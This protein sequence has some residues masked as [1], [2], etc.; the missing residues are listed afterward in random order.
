MPKPQSYARSRKLRKKRVALFNA[1]KRRALPML[2]DR[3]KIDDGAARHVMLYSFGI[4]Y[5]TLNEA[6]QLHIKD[7]LSQ[8]LT[9]GTRRSLELYWR[10]Y[11]ERIKDM[12]VTKLM[13][14]RMNKF[15]WLVDLTV[16]YLEYCYE[17]QR[18]ERLAQ[19]EIN[20]KY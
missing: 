9:Y 19:E 13:D 11:L 4:K 1:H 3:V 6:Y 2:K 20:G 16:N 17:R 7:N 5:D 18:E 8:M 14:D 10:E 15:D 12:Y